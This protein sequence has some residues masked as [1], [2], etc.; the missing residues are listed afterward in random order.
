MYEG[1]KFYDLEW[2]EPVLFSD[3]PHLPITKGYPLNN[4]TIV[5]RN[6]DGEEI[7]LSDLT[8][9]KREMYLAQY[10]GKVV[11]LVKNKMKVKTK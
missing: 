2:E 1:N 9:E 6:N 5:D 3:K 8:Q 4:I 11:D 10:T 7:M